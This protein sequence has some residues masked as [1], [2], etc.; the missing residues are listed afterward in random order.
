ME[1]WLLLPH[2]LALTVLLR[3]AYRSAHGLSH[4]SLPVATSTDEFFH[5]LFYMTVKLVKLLMRLSHPR[6][7]E[8]GRVGV[9][10]LACNRNSWQWVNRR[11]INGATGTFHSLCMASSCRVKMSLTV[12]RSRIFKICP[13]SD[14][15]Q[16][17]LSTMLRAT[18]RSWR[19]LVRR[20]LGCRDR[21]ASDERQTHTTRSAASV[22]VGLESF[23]KGVFPIKPFWFTRNPVPPRLTRHR[24]LVEKE[25]EL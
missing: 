19:P 15:L 17:A 2:S 6:T 5:G 22:H 8:T 16:T 1:T 14:D 10:T 23:L 4:P 9:L 7:F 3:P 21:S 25:V 20:M 13:S 12:L 18:E 11:G 24:P